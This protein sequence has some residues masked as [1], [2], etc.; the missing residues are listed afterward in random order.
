ME[1]C[2]PFSLKNHKRFVKISVVSDGAIA[3]AG[4]QKITLNKTDYICDTCRKNLYKKNIKPVV[5]ESAPTSTPQPGPSSSV[6]PMIIDDDLDVQEM[7][8]S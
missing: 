6:V 5:E 8:Q 4:T 7:T 1:C 2:N 3:K